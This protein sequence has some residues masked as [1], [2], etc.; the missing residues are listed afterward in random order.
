MTQ[1]KCP[2]CQRIPP[3]ADSRVPCGP[4]CAASC[5]L[6]R[7]GFCCLPQD[8]RTASVACVLRVCGHD[9]VRAFRACERV[10]TIMQVQNSADLV[11]HV[12]AQVVYAGI[13][14]DF[15]VVCL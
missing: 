15:R 2:Q 8:E 4:L 14:K 12:D 1:V 6:C 7:L 3:G 5:R 9:I 10:Y 11:L 13:N